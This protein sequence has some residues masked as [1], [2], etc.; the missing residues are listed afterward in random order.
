MA[1]FL[2]EIFELLWLINSK[3]PYESKAKYT[4]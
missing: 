1:S 2:F 3:N 4:Y